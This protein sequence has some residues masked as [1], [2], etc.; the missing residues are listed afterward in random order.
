MIKIYDLTY[1]TLSPGSDYE[2]FMGPVVFSGSQTI[3]AI[4]IIDDNVDESTET[5]RVRL[6]STSPGVVVTG[7][8]FATVTIT[9]PDSKL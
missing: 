6:S 4:P 1:L 3:I 2:E 8:D 9:D 7:Q 5:F